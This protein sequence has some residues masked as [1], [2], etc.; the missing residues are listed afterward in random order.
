MVLVDVGVAWW[1]R[2]K[3][4]QHAKTPIDILDSYNSEVNSNDFQGNL[5]Y[6]SAQIITT[7]AEVTPKGSLVGESSENSLKSG[8]GIIVVIGPGINQPTSPRLLR[9]PVK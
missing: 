7:S 2:K 4:R 1:D 6:Q 8:L 5:L 9:Q 3:Q